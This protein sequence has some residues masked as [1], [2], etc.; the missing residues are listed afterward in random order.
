MAAVF[1]ENLFGSGT[2][3]LNSRSLTF[4][5]IVLLLQSLNFYDFLIIGVV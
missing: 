5:L 4:E 2:V 3:D 1:V